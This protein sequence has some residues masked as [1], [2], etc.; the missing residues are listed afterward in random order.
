MRNIAPCLLCKSKFGLNRIFSVKFDEIDTPTEKERAE[1]NEIQARTDA[2]LVQ[3]GVI[4]PDEVR[5]KLINSENSGY[6]GIDEEMQEEPFED[7]TEEEEKDNNGNGGYFTKE[8]L[9]DTEGN[10]ETQQNPF[11][12]DQWKE[13]DPRKANGQFGKGGGSSSKSNEEFEDKEQHEKDMKH[14]FESQADM[15][16]LLAMDYPEFKE[17]VSGINTLYKSNYKNKKN[18][19]HITT[20]FIYKA[21][22]HGFNNYEFYDKIINDDT[23]KDWN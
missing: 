8:R 20:A 17:T 16:T 2:T 11:S 18:I 15:M 12:T 3:A 23:R 19:K 9:K 10:G 6:N 4:A 22:N 1:I 13:G 7:E 21:H 5:Q 14:S